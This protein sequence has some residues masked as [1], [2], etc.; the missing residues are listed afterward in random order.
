MLALPLRA[1]CFRRHTLAAALSGILAIASPGVAVRAQG[2]ADEAAIRAAML[3]NVARFT[4][5]P[6]WKMDAEHPQFLICFLG[7]DPIDRYAD[8]ILDHQTIN[9][10]PVSVRH[11]KPGEPVEP[12][13]IL[14]TSVANRKF[15]THSK[16]ELT[17]AAVL[18]VSELSNNL[19]PDQIVGLPVDGDHVRIEIN[20]TLA[21][22]SSLRISSRI[23]RLASVTP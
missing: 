4:D 5:W 8:K 12:C 11:L 13:H 1:W 9:D 22:Q 15:L 10:K 2:S 20:L 3:L 23:L 14:Y 17:K 18:S 19:T 6:T 16:A 7:A 21:Q